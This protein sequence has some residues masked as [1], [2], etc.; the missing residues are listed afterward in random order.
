MV[1]KV[2][3][4]ALLINSHLSCP[5]QPLYQFS[6]GSLCSHHH[7]AANNRGEYTRGGIARGEREREREREKKRDER[8]REGRENERGERVSERRDGVREQHERKSGEHTLG[9]YIPQRERER[10]R[11]R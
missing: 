7:R 9:F 6:L 2:L 5:T 4:W 1:I 11:E 8:E 10:E 3:N